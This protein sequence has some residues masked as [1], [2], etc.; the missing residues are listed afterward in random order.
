MIPMT[1]PSPLKAVGQNV[2]LVSFFSG[3]VRSTPGYDKMRQMRS[4]VA[5]QT[6]VT[7]GSQVWVNY[8]IQGPPDP[9]TPEKGPITMEF[10]EIC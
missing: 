1:Y 6:G 8:S 7:V 9:P 5:L 3:T 2:M 4:F 10:D